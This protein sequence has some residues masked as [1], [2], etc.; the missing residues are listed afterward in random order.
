MLVVRRDEDESG[1]VLAA[2]EK[3][4]GHLESIEAGHLHIQKDEI[5]VHPVNG[6]QRLEAVSRLPDDLD[7]L[8]LFELEAQLRPRMLFIVNDQGSQWHGAWG[9]G[10][11]VRGLLV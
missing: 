11:F 3:P 2:L 5:R 6:R 9:L 8:V 7:V 1:R 10:S 4:P